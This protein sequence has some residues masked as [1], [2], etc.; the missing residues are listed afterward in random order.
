[1]LEE[2]FHFPLSH[3][4]ERLWFIDQLDPAAPTYNISSALRLSGELNIA[5]LSNS[6]DE[7]IRRHEILR[8]TFSS[9]DGQPVQIISSHRTQTLSLVDL[10]DLDS[11]ESQAVRLAKADAQRG[12]DLERGP[13]LRATLLRLAPTEHI[14]LF[15][16]HHIISDG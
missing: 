11:K 13:L 7:I 16:L 4:Q 6:I 12:F 15:A 5:A 9:V 8:T 1:M 14:A 2:V 10:S 3:A